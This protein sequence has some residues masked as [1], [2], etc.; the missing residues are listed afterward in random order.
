MWFPHKA[1][2]SFESCNQYENFLKWCDMVG[3]TADNR[4]PWT[5]SWT[6]NLCLRIYGSTIRAWATTAYYR[7]TVGKE[8][9]RGVPFEFLFCTPEYYMDTVAPVE[10]VEEAEIDLSWLL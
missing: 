9:Q 10:E 6:S 2:V 1:L 8:W 4:K 5:C 3:V 7:G